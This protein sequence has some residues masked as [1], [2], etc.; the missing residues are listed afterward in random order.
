MFWSLDTDDFEGVF[1]GDGDFP[2]INAAAHQFAAP[3]E[4]N[5]PIY[6]TNETQIS[7]RKPKPIMSPMK[8]SKK[9][10]NTDQ[11]SVSELKGQ[12]KVSSAEPKSV[13]TIK[14]STQAKLIQK[15]PFRANK[16]SALSK[17][18]TKSQQTDS[19]DRTNFNNQNAQGG[20]DSKVSMTNSK[21]PSKDK[22]NIV[23]DIKKT[24]IVNTQNVESEAKSTVSNS[25]ENKLTNKPLKGNKKP[26]AIE[27]IVTTTKP[28]AENKPKPKDAQTKSRKNPKPPPN[29]RRLKA[30]KRRRKQW[31]RRRPPSKRQRRKNNKSQRSKN[32]AKASN[33]LKSKHIKKNKTSQK[34]TTPATTKLQSSTTESRKV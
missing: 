30:G 7:K 28:S 32:K 19:Q 29:R 1:C 12:E 34:S 10:I 3:V 2:L 6:T 8:S 16:A 27:S 25:S 15:K 17:A 23:D 24:E 26:N 13:T 14:S 21:P 33:S 31:R 9:V 4:L 20:G 5:R 11:S 18:L 22:T